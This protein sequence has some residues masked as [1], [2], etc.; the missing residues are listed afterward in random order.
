MSIEITN[1]AG[2]E[3]MPVGATG[4]DRDGWPIEKVSDTEFIA[5]E[6]HEDKRAGRWL[7]YDLDEFAGDYDE[8][9]SSSF[10][11]IALDSNWNPVVRVIDARLKSAVASMEL[12]S[13]KLITSTDV[14]MLIGAVNVDVNEVYRLLSLHKCQLGHDVHRNLFDQ[15]KALETRMPVHF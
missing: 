11:P 3:A 8:N 2:L 14:P 9:D 4:V 10:L 12:A 1:R 13:S 7:H 6:Q 5:Q 15:V